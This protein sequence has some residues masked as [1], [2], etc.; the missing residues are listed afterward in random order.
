M[1]LQDELK[2][3]G[4]LFLFQEKIYG[5][6]SRRNTT[7]YAIGF[8]VATSLLSVLLALSLPLP[9]PSPLFVI[10]LPVIA[11][12]ITWL[13]AAI[14]HACAL[15]FK[16]VGSITNLF[17]VFG[18]L[19][20]IGIL[21][22][23]GSYIELWVPFLDMVVSSLVGLYSMALTISAIKAVEG[24]SWAKAIAVLFIP[25]AVFV[26]FALFLL[27]ELAASYPVL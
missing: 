20:W 24:L 5:D 16:G 22:V 27:Y 1:T 6:V 12:G 4:E 21:Q 13:S 17:R 2:K 19:S 18:Y 14:F 15:L 3:V 26:L 10:F 23:L 8:I 25:L 9:K 11:L 7:T